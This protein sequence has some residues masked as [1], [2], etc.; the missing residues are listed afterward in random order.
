MERVV[1][2][3]LPPEQK[4]VTVAAYLQAQGY[5]RHLLL[6]LKQQPGSILVDGRPAR[7]LQSLTGGM[8]LRV[9]VPEPAASAV[10]PAAQPLSL[11]YEDEDVV[12]V[13]KPAGLNVHPSGK[14]HTQSI[15]NGLAAYYQQQGLAF[16]C[17][18]VYR[19]DRHTS[20]LVLVAKNLLSAG[21]LWEQQRRRE[22][23]R[24]YAAVVVGE[25][26]PKGRIV[27]PIGRETATSLRR[28]VDWQRGKVAATTFEQVRQVRGYTLLRVGLETGRTHQIRV[29]LAYIGYPL[30]G[31]ALYGG[32]CRLLQRQALHSSL[33]RFRQPVSGKWLTFTAPLPQ[34]VR[35]LWEE[36]NRD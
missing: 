27:A 11:L 24:Q 18:A 16:T 6:L 30:V 19:L 20:G 15:A 13:N 28:Q 23:Q 5:S 12:V 7:H 31:D 8:M 25:P 22:M 29:H 17:R 36:G 3:Q 9:T 26:P 33:L 35:A 14:L 34:D 21:L 1:H 4:P 2:Y 32:D 10:I